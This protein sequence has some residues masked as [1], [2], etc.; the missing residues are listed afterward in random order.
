LLACQFR[1]HPAE[2][3]KSTGRANPVDIDFSEEFDPGVS[4]HSRFQRFSPFQDT[5]A[6][7]SK[8]IYPAYRGAQ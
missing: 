2:T 7:F 3:H 4:E 5:L 1:D 6:G 8:K